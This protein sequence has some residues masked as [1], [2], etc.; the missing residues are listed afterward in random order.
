MK[1]MSGIAAEV[2]LIVTTNNDVAQRVVFLLT[3]I[4]TV[5]FKSSGHLLPK[6]L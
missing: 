3:M 1:M 6:T 4:A 5:V 2:A